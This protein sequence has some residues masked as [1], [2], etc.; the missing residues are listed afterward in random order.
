MEDSIEK[1]LPGDIPM[2]IFSAGNYIPA[3]FHM[4]VNHR[5]HQENRSS[6][7]REQ[8]KKHGRYIGFFCKKTEKARN[9]NDSIVGKQIQH[10]NGE[11][12]VPVKKGSQKGQEKKCQKRKGNITID[13][14][15]DACRNQKKKAVETACFGI[16]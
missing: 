10:W 14:E 13:Q 15:P 2:R 3:W 12:E 11:P 8:V 4:A 16:P 5:N 7:Q 6:N 1:I 9:T